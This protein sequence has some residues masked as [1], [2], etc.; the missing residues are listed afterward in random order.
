MNKTL[1]AAVSAAAILAGAFSTSAMAAREGGDWIFRAGMTNVDPK[2]VADSDLNL[3]IDDDTAVS[4]TGV[5]MFTDGFGIELLASTPF[6]HDFSVDGVQVGSTKHLPP[7]LNLQYYFNAA[8]EFHPYVGAGINYTTFFSTKSA[9]DGLKLDDS[10]GYD[11]Q[12][13][14]DFE[15]SERLLLNLDVRWIKIESDVKVD[16]DKIGTAKI[17][18]MT[19]GINLGWKF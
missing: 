3:T 12:A 8:G 6:E 13:G 4:L 14:V 11:V 7:T 1:V 15:I 5:Y 19:V 9:I 18:P 10:F 17:D 16:G 2:Q